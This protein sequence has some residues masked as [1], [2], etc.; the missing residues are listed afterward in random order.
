MAAYTIVIN[1]TIE[2]EEGGGKKKSRTLGI[3]SGPEDIIATNT[4]ANLYRTEAW[5]SAMDT[6]QRGNVCQYPRY[7]IGLRLLRKQF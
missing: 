3:I 6:A 2:E 1:E 5:W 7:E 4:F